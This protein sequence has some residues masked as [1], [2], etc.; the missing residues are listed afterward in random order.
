M[1]DPELL[2]LLELCFGKIENELSKYEERVAGAG[3]LLHKEV[4]D[5]L[6]EVKEELKKQ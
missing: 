6:K 1:I 3:K 4:G 5:I 2:K